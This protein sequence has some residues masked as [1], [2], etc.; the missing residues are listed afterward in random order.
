[1]FLFE[2]ERD[3]LHFRP[4]FFQPI[5]PHSNSNFES[6]LLFFK[7]ISSTKYMTRLT[8]YLPKIE[9]KQIVLTNASRNRVRERG[10]AI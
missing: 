8:K 5:L 7:L 6:F 1:M 10:K 3:D 9:N 2:C 4:L